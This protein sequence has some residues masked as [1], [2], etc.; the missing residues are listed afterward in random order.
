MGTRKPRRN[1][2]VRILQSPYHI[3]GPAFPI[4][5]MTQRLSHAPTVWLGGSHLV[6]A[7]REKPAEHFS[8]V[9][10]DVDGA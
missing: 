9:L 6:L 8:R 2:L 5:P 10:V 3:P 1:Q 7:L 4:V